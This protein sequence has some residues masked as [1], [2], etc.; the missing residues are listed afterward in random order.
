MHTY[1]CGYTL[2]FFD[3]IGYQNRKVRINVYIERLIVAT[4]L[5]Q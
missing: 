5:F 3:N 4:V 1:S 2:Y